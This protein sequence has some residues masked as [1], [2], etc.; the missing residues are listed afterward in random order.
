MEGIDRQSRGTPL[1]FVGMVRCQQ[2][3]ITSQVR[4][5]GVGLTLSGKIFLVLDCAQERALELSRRALTKSIFV[6]SGERCSKKDAGNDTPTGVSECKNAQACVN[7]SY[8]ISYIRVRP[9]QCRI[10]HRA[11]RSGAKTKSWQICLSVDVHECKYPCR[12]LSVSITKDAMV[13]TLLLL[14]W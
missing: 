4:S 14:A 9:L 2:I 1:Y 10:I 3:R 12:M 6:H 13:P 5:K 8:A 11:W 7:E